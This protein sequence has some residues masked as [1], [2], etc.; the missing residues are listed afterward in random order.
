MGKKARLKKERRALRDKSQK[1][2]LEKESK[3]LQALGEKTLFDYAHLK[4][5][6]LGRGVVNVHSIRKKLKYITKETIEKAVKNKPTETERGILDFLS[7]Y[8][9]HAE[10]VMFYHSDEYGTSEPLTITVLKKSDVEPHKIK[11]LF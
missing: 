4:Y 6:E 11:D 3:E 5:L 2:W 8:D 1:S 9:P 7:N 10:L